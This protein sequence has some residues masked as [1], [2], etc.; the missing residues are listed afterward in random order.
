MRTILPGS[1]VSCTACE[2]LSA[3]ASGTRHKRMRPICPSF[4]CAATI[5]KALP[6]AP[7]P[8]LADFSPPMYVSSTSYNTRQAVTARP[9]HC[10]PELLQPCPGGF[11]PWQSQ[12]PLKP[13][14]A[15]TDFL[16]GYVPDGPKPQPQGFSRILKDGAGR[17]RDLVIAM[18]ATIKPP[19]GRPCLPMAT[20]RATKPCRPPQLKQI[21]A[22]GL[23]SKNLFKFQDGSGVIFNVHE[24]HTTCRG[25][26]SKPDTPIIF[27]VLIEPQAQKHVCTG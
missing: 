14:S 23:G 27:F 24:P 15:D 26:G 7:R 3:E 13:Q 4:S 20:S 8:R 18:T 10:Y 9:Y 2:R 25:R 1:T 16:R 21:L 12:N 6:P 5:T 22:A 11:I 19:L 17:H